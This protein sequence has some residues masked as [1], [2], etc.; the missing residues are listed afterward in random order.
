MPKLKKEVENTPLGVDVIFNSF[1]FK[2]WTHAGCEWVEWFLVPVKES[3]TIFGF[4][5]AGF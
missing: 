4:R 1:H 3:K 5:A 2:A